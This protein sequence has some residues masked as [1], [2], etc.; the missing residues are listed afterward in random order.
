M[1]KESIMVV[2]GQ[3]LIGDITHQVK[4]KPNH[5]PPGP[6]SLGQVPIRTTIPRTSPHQDHNP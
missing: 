3:L 2:L 1:F 4:I 5:C 6:R